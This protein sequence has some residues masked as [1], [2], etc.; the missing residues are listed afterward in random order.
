MYTIVL[1]ERHCGRQ[2]VA[3]A[4]AAASQEKWASPFSVSADFEANI[5]C[6]AAC[7]VCVCDE[8]SRIDDVEHKFRKLFLADDRAIVIL[9]FA[10]TRCALY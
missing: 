6:A 8:T 9:H 1:L 3:A 7:P 2:S 4:A 5:L 10:R